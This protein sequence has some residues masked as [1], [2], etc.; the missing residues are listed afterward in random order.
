MYVRADNGVCVDCDVWESLAEARATI[1][2]VRD[3][4]RQKMLTVDA[5]RLP[6]RAYQE[7]LAV[8]ADA[9]DA[10]LDGETDE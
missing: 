7:V 1:Q 9:L 3:L 8:R 10:A 5:R 2:R 6:P 4:P